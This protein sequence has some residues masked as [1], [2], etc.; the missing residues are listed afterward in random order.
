MGEGGGGLSKEETP[1]LRQELG[2]AI[3][4]A[5]PGIPLLPN[6]PAEGVCPTA[7]GQALIAIPSTAP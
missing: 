4:P 6:P 3:S 1:A 7:G 5:R 2:G